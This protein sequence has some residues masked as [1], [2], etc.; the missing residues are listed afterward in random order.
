MVKVTVGGKEFYMDGYLQKN[1]DKAREKITKDWDMVFIVDG[2]EG[3]GK[4]VL[5]QQI[6]YYCDPTFNLDN[7]CFSDHEFKEQLINLK[8][9]SIIYDEA[10]AGLSSAGA[11]SKIN[12]VLKKVLHE[13]RQN[14]NVAVIVLPTF[15]DLDKMAA[16]WRSRALFHVYTDDW[17]RGFYSFFNKDQK[18][19]L[20]MH[21]KK[22]Y[23]YHKG[24]PAFYGRF[25]NFYT[26]D[27]A[28]YR[29]KKAKY[30]RA[31]LDDGE[32]K[33]LEK[34]AKR[35]LF[36]KLYEYDNLKEKEKAA[37]LGISLQCYYNWR[38]KY[39]ESLRNA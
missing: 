22:Y 33:V 18:L 19:Y 15:F 7:I 20:F 21:G 28:A 32:D 36:K 3:S 1:L 16:L 35:L 10:Y 11:M 27:E 34:K 12:R 4:S 17:K 5:A 30:L 31:T 2:Y 23:E 9:K 24:R 38:N 39:A 8:K 14:S 6:A 26:V 25:T 37:I 29:D 13:C